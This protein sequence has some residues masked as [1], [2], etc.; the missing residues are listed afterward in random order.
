MLRMRLDSVDQALLRLLRLDGRRSAAS[1]AAEVGLS[2]SACHRRIKLLEERGVIVGYTAVVDAGAEGD[3]VIA[4]VQLTLE[5]QTEQYFS[6]LE[7]AIRRLPE[8]REC[9]LVSGEF[10][11]FLK[12]VVPNAAAYESLHLKALSRLPGV[13]KLQTSLAIRDPG[14]APAGERRAAS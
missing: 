5:R 3:E 12:V 1:L 13:I 9:L 11:Y 4:I 6:R 8:V 14:R 7:A 10:D 2:P